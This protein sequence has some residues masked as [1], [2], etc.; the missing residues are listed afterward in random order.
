MIGTFDAHIHLPLECVKKERS[1]ISA[2]VRSSSGKA[3]RIG[4]TEGMKVSEKQGVLKR[5][6]QLGWLEKKTLRPP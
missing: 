6:Q 3:I 4:T 1:L 2:R 5:S